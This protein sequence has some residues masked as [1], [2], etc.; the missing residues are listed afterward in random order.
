[1]EM[2]HTPHA[3]LMEARSYFALGVAI[4]HLHLA[5][6][7]IKGCTHACIVPQQHHVHP[8]PMEGSPYVHHRPNSLRLEIVRHVDG[9]LVHSMTM[10]CRGMHIP[11]ASKALL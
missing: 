11:C 6:R 9:F 4:I 10:A 5:S 7:S 2:F 1:M 3:I 8:E